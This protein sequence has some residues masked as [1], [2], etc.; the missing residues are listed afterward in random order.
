MGRLN[1]KARVLSGE[2]CVCRKL[3]DSATFR[4][5]VC[6]LEWGI[7]SGEFTVFS[8]KVKSVQD[9]L[10]NYSCFPVTNVLFFFARRV[11]C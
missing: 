7:G 4:A 1:V 5:R 9:S 11:V 6:V 2:W 3:I 8:G 10:K